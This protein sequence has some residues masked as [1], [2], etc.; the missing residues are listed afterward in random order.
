[1]KYGFIN[2]AGRY[3]RGADF[4]M[5]SRFIT[6]EM[7]DFFLSLSIAYVDDERRKDVEGDPFVSI[8]NQERRLRSRS[9]LSFS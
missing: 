4:G 5:S 6:D 7:G 9:Y 3:Y 2:G 1:M 8:M